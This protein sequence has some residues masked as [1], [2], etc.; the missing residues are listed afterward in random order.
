MGHDGRQ[1]TYGWVDA[2]KD[3]VGLFL[4]QRLIEGRSG[5]GPER[6]AFVAMAAAA[7]VD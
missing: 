6:A 4:I 2:K 3:L 7:I 1:G 5:H